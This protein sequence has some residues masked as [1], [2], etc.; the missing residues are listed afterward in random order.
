MAA[1]A[2]VETGRRARPF[3]LW[4]DRAFRAVALG[5]G[6]AVLVILGLIAFYTT[7]EAWPVFR[8]E[9]IGFVA[10]DNWDP[11]N[12]HFGALSLVYGTV[13][14]SAIALVIAVP[15]SIG[16]ALFTNEVASERLRASI[17]YVV[18]LLAA[19]PSIVYGLWGL[20]V[21]V[22]WANSWYGSIA[23]TI[24]TLPVLDRVFGGPATGA[25]IM[26]AGIIL[27]VMITPIITSL[28]R[29]VL[30]TVPQEDKNAALAMG[31]TRWEMLRVAVFPRV[32]G[33]LVGA[34]MLGLGR[35]MGET[36]AVA[37]LIGSSQQ[38]TLHLFQPGDTLAAAIAHDWSEGQG[39][40]LWRAALIGLGVVLFVLTIAI[41][42]AA[43]AIASRSMRL[44]AG[45][46]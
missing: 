30:A 35:A 3:D 24:G 38:I 5:A 16:I 13:M 45:A 6:F 41:N 14:S 9:G 4:S 19:V 22:L 20:A 25:S 17:V 39:Y 26:T 12:N 42:M 36:I 34:V 44:E 43:R 23:R 18:D 33:G 7:K 1:L 11:S 27:S 31:A 21:F 15:T 8:H 2:P 10:T 29:E 40:P 32:R 37:L 28:S 46:P